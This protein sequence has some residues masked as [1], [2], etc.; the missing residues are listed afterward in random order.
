MGIYQIL[1][2][3]IVDGFSYNSII[4]N[5]SFHYYIHSNDR[6]SQFIINGR[7]YDKLIFP[8]KEIEKK[9]YMDGIGE[10]HIY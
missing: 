6:E 7:K 5:E 4:I 8:R 1:D 10:I 3:C 9:N 2:P